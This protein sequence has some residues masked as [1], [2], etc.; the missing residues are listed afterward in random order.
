MDM[1]NDYELVYLAKNECCEHAINRLISKY[2]KLIYRVIHSLQVYYHDISDYYQEG[3]MILLKAIKCFDETYN[4]T[5]T[6]YF[7]LILIRHLI[8]VKRNTPKYILCEDPNYLEDCTPAYFDINWLEVKFEHPMEAR[9]H[10][11]YFINKQT[12]AEIAKME[13][14][15]K[16]QIYNAIYRIKEKYK[17]NY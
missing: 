16:K 11:L 1:N 14:L 12:I 9:I 4:K 6:R 13:S 8:R 10:E 15:S 7:E 5:F 3:V 17:K 2:E